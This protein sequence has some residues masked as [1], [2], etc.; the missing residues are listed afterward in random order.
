MCFRRLEDYWN[1]EYL[2]FCLSYP[3]F[4]L[5]AVNQLIFII[6]LLMSLSI[7]SC[8]LLNIFLIKP[9]IIFC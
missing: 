1:N 3:K 9:V 4:S 6:F 7:R 8:S 2:F 5:F